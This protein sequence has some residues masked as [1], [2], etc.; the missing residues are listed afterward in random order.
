M[1]SSK[2]VQIDPNIL[3]EYRYSRGNLFQE[4]YNVTFNRRHN[5]LSYSAQD[6]TSSLNRLSNQ[7]TLV[8]PVTNKYGKVDTDTYSF[9]Q[10]KDYIQLLPLE[11]DIVRFYFPSNYTFE[12]KKGFYM[13]LYS[14]DFNNRLKFDISNYFFDISDQSRFISEFD[15]LLEPLTYNGKIWGKFIEVSVPSINA[16]SNQRVNDSPSPN[17]INYILTN[18]TGLSTTA[19]VFLDFYFINKV[20]ELGGITSYITANP[21]STSFPQ[22]P[23]F[24]N[25]SVKIEPSK[26]GDW[27]DIFGIYNSSRGEFNSF[28][29]T[30]ISIGKRYV[31]EYIITLFEENLKGKSQR[32]LISENFNQTVEYRP[33]IKFSSTTA[34]ID[35][36][37]RLIDRVSNSTITRNSSYILRSNELNKYSRRSLSISTLNTAT[38]II[39]NR[40]NITVTPDGNNKS[41]APFSSQGVLRA[42]FPVLYEKNRIVIK[43][44]NSILDGNLY[45]GKGKLR[46]VLTPFDNVI[47]FVIAKNIE[48]KFEA[49]NLLNM[50]ELYLV[51]KNDN[52]TVEIQVYQ[53]SDENDFERGSIVFRI[54]ERKTSDIKKIFNTDNDSFYIITKS[55]NSSTVIYNGTFIFSDNIE[56]R[57]EQED[58]FSSDRGDVEIR[59]G[60]DLSAVVSTAASNINFTNAQNTEVAQSLLETSRFSP[61]N[62]LLQVLQNQIRIR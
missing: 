39:Y 21:I 16:I 50:G 13:N 30:S 3:I 36:E 51:F 31:V 40:R 28:I 14:V 60:S 7:L 57:Q 11:R 4:N 35:V 55:N 44:D 17:S 43:S 20:Q 26:N 12:D 53:Q 61:G 58:D 48:D 25:L 59:R 9:L 45:K 33:I 27:F 56:Y 22:T 15:G 8:D 10:V 19:P 42:D 62:S 46:I 29:E 54:P 6:S 1:E 41:V 18:K 47:K 2:F 49:F 23:D 5:A 52:T 34:V 32:I 38:P 37:M 24:K